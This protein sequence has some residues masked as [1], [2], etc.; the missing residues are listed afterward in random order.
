MLVSDLLFAG[1][2]PTLRTLASGRGDALL[3]HL[4]GREDLEPTVRGDLRLVDA[5]TGRDVEVGIADDALERFRERRDAWLAEVAAVAGSHGIAH[6]RMVD[7]AD[8]TDLLLHDLRA[9]GVVS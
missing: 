6:A 4:L 5:E 1:W 8:V 9:L 7:D 2:E 3:V